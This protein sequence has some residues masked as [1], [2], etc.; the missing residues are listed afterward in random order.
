MLFLNGKIYTDQ[1]FVEAMYVE[2]GIIKALGSSK[3]LLNMYPNQ[4]VI[5]FKKNLVLPGFNDSHLHLLSFARFLDALNLEAAKSINEIISLGKEALVSRKLLIMYGYDD[6]FFSAPLSRNDLDSISREIPIIAYRSC[7][8][9]ATVN[10]AVMMQVR[11][12]L[13]PDLINQNTGVF[14]ENAI[15]LLDELHPEANLEML[16]KQ[17]ET[18]VNYFHRFGITSIGS[19]DLK[20][21]V[22]MGRKII[23]AYR[24][25]ENEEKLNLRVS[26]Q[27]T[28]TEKDKI[29]EILEFR[30]ESPFFRFGPLKLFLDGSLGGK[31]ALLSKPY[32]DGTYGIQ[33]LPRETLEDLL[34]FSEQENLQVAVH[35]IGDQASALF[36]EAFQKHVK[37]NTNRHF[38]IHL[39]VLR[40]DLFKMLKDFQVRAAVQPIFLVEDLKMAKAN[41]PA[42]LLKTS[43]A[44][45]S[46]NKGT[47]IAFGSDAPYGGLNPFAGL[48][49]AVTQSN[50]EG[51]VLNLEEKMPLEEALKAYTLNS[52]YLTFEEKKK[53]KLKQGFYADFIVLNKDL[54]LL[55]EN[56]LGT[57]EVLMTVVGGKV[58]YK[59]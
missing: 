15:A 39:Q 31:T 17:I 42:S 30:S 26:L 9:I 29:K 49:A 16:K 56:E 18:T 52:A 54:F 25:L 51:E 46:L 14:K 11:S 37:S 48:Q 43:Y 58:V 6:S 57:A 59:K 24:E 47:V 21:D 55:P 50:L 32:S 19:N 22:A 10:S 8:H 34:A 28:F 23:T 13:F 5:D 44:F 36:L 3:A 40:E 38:L 12:R 35:A 2:G 4:E 1:G 27:F 20:D 33:T 41:L 45:Q 7:G 53:G